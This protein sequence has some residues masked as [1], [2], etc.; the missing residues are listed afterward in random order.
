MISNNSSKSEYSAYNQ[1]F[2]QINKDWIKF[3]TEIND[4]N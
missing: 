4:A 1:N 2:Y 3:I